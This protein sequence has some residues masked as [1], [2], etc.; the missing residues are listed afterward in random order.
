[1]DSPN[2][3]ANIII[4]IHASIGPALPTPTSVLAQPHWNTATITP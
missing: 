1:M 4:G 2:T 3:T